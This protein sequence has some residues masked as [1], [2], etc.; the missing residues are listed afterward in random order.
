MM[1]CGGMPVRPNFSDGISAFAIDIVSCMTAHSSENRP[2]TILS[3]D[4]PRRTRIF[5]E[6][7][8]VSSLSHAGLMEAMVPSSEC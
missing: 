7:V 8:G 3:G 4:D 6:W 1:A 5:C 2:R